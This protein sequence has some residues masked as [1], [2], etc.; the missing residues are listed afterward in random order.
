MIYVILGMHKSGT[1]LVSQILHHSGIN[2]GSHVENGISYDQ[3]NQYERESTWR[4]NEEI[5]HAGQVR[6]IDI[7]LP[8]S[9]QLTAVQQQR[10]RDIIESCSQKYR[11]WGFKDPRTCLVYPLWAAELPPHRLIVIY[12]HPAEPWPR[13]RPRHAYNRFREPYRAWKYLRSWHAHN[14]R[15]LD[16]L[17]QTT[18]EYL[19][20]EYK[21]LMTNQAAFDR[22]QAFVGMPLCDRRQPGLYRHHVKNYRMLSLAEWVLSKTEGYHTPSILQ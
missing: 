18:S 17:Q 9:W 22:L 6:S 20:L 3:G 21:Q 8:G 16:Y 7:A 5:L 4:L 10:M 11:H 15:I 12:R 14:A 19:V 1:T 13:Y 2:M